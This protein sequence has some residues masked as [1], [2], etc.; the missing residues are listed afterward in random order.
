[1]SATPLSS[2]YDEIGEGLPEGATYS[3]P[4]EL[5]DEREDIGASGL[6][7]PVLARH[8]DLRC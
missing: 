6:F 5:P 1:V 4:G 3:R 7:E 2:V 8:F